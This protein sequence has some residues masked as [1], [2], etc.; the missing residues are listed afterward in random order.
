[1]M[2]LLT[3][4]RALLLK[5]RREKRE[6]HQRHVSVGDLLT[7]RRETA[8]ELDFGEGTSC[9]D[10]VLVLG[11]VTVGKNCWIGPNVV[12]DGSGGLS[13]GDHIDISA[14]VQIYTHDTLRRVSSEGVD[15]IDY[16]PTRIGSRVYIG[17]QTVI[18]KGVVIG[19]DVVIGTLSF[20]NRDIPSGAKVWG[21]PAKPRT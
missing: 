18:Q 6:L 17:P 9:Y 2:E 13:I 21:V 5:L 20:V 14:G 7:D 12:L 1:M 15:K 19:D 4:V 3:T 10:N 16:A 8:R 11:K